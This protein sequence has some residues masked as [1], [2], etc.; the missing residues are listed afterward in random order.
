MTRRPE[1]LK[2]ETQQNSKNI[3]LTNEL[4]NSAVAFRQTSPSQPPLP[5][6]DVDPEPRFK[7]P[8]SDGLNVGFQRVNIKAGCKVSC[9][10]FLANLSEGS[11][12]DSVSVIRQ[13]FKPL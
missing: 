6:A 3:A 9:Y 10:L 8:F 5:S 11:I 2:P 7:R 12:I 1:V 13:K 4:P